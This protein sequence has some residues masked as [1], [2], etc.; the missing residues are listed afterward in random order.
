MAWNENAVKKIKT[1]R[2]LEDLVVRV[3][4]QNLQQV[5]KIK[6]KGRKNEGL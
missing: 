2:S 3:G 1:A 4:W 5:N 6:F